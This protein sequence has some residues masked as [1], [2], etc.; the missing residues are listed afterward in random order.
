M[1]TNPVLIIICAVI[2]AFNAFLIFIYIKSKFNSFP[3]YF[4][5]FFC[6]VISLNNI[7]RLIHRNIGEDTDDVTTLCKIQAVLL[8]LFDK[9]L[10]ALVWYLFTD[11]LCVAFR[12]VF[13]F[14][15]LGGWIK[16][17]SITLCL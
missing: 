5:I 12:R 13:F 11:I 7:I 8:T 10:L 17:F 16:L 4:N 9:L 1:A 15:L 6:V 2:V 14:G 3:Y